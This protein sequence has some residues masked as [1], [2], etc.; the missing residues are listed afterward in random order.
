MKRPFADKRPIGPFA[1]MQKSSGVELV[2]FTNVDIPQS[3]ADTIKETAEEEMGR[4]MEYVDVMEEN[5]GFVINTGPEILLDHPDFRTYTNM[6][7][8]IK[9]ELSYE[10]AEG[11]KYD[12]VTARC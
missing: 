12:E 8:A 2:C 6:L 9:T 1:Q 3:A 4:S 10:L 5:M 7:S 11:V